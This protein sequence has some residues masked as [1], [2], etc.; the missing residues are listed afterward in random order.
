MKILLVEPPVSP[1]D[2]PTK[3][4]ALPPPHHLE[5][6]AGAVLTN[7]D[8]W[9]LDMRVDNDLHPVLDRFQ[10]DLIGCSCVAANSHLAKRVLEEAKKFNP[11]IITVIGGHHPSLMPEHCNEPFIDLVVM[12]EGEETLCEIAARGESNLDL[13]TI[14]GTASHTGTGDFRINP[15]RDLMNLGALPMPARHLT[16]KH[17]KIG[18]SI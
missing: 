18:L 2:V 3:V 14:K 8:V 17:R 1:F 13:S 16:E 5:R 7:H 11:E 10:P 9:I 15:Q 4:L 12:G 6:L